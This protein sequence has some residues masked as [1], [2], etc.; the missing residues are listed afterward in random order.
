MFAKFKEMMTTL[1]VSISFHVVLELIPKFTKFMQA[2]LKGTKQ[3]LVKERVNMTKKDEMVE[4]QALP[5][6]M[7]GPGKFTTACAIGEVKI[8]HALC[9]SGSSINVMLLNKFKEL[10]MGEIIPSNMTLTLADPSV[11]H[12]MVFYKTC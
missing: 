4:P 8:P 9:D 7:K 12:L 10:K 6:K 11:T 3:K 5:P 1:H 2:L